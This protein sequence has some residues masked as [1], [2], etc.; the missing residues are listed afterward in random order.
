VSRSGHYVSGV[1]HEHDLD[2]AEDHDEQDDH[3]E[4]GVDGGRPAIT[5]SMRSAQQ[6][7]LPQTVPSADW[8]ML[9]NLSLATPQM[10]TTKALV[11]FPG[12]VLRLPAESQG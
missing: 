3:R 9:T 10:A 4:D 6:P 5:E 2:D 12:Q 7:R 1:Q 11:I 8:T